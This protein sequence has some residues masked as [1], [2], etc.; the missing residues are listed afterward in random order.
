M[1]DNVTLNTMSGGSTVK[2]DDDGSAHWQYI[3]V[4]FGA[5]NTQTR[6]TSSTGLPVLLLTGSSAI[7]KLAA[8]SGVDIGDVDVTSVPAPLNITGAGAE[9]TALR[10]T[11]ANEASSTVDGGNI[12][13]SAG[14]NLN[15]SALATESGGNLDTISGATTDIN[16]KILVGAGTEAGAILVTIANDST[17]LLTVDTAG[18]SGLEVVQATAADLNVTEVSSITISNAVAIM[19][20]WSATHAS[21]ASADGPQVMG[22]GYSAALPT[23]IGSDADS[24]RLL[25]D[26]F[27]RL[28]A[29][30]Q[31]QS[32]STSLDS[33]NVTTAVTVIS[34]VASRKPYITSFIISASSAG[35]Y[36]FEDANASSV[37]SKFYFADN[38]GVSYTCPEGTPLVAKSTNTALNIKG[39]ILGDVGVTITYYLAE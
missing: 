3:K 11:L 25:T 4:S 35:N 6:V 30:L 10:V 1:A 22:A 32:A 26:R 27:G 13:A 23:D 16:N 21:A 17:G 28:V 2:T 24:A 39:S 20:N 8:N 7:G 12:T 31:P 34:A 29:G 37:S 36:W 5:D 38:G 9:A 14:A 19:A 15:T 18:T 33:A